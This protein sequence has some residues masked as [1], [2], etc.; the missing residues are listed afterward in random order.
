MGYEASRQGSP[1][2]LLFGL[3]VH[4]NGGPLSETR[5]SIYLLESYLLWSFI[6]YGIH[7]YALH[8]YPKRFLWAEQTYGIHVKHH[9]TPIPKA[10]SFPIVSWISVTCVL[11]ATRSRCSDETFGGSSPATAADPIRVGGENKSRAVRERAQTSAAAATCYFIN[12]AL[13]R[14]PLIRP[15]FRVWRA[16][17]LALFATAT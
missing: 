16:R 2:V 12:S 13:K 5:Y 9:K 11:A 1:V 17:W 8:W 7:D 14:L 10:L 6:E 15:S 3:A 4:L